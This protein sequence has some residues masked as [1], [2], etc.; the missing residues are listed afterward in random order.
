[1]GSVSTSKLA[2][3]VAD[4]GGVGSIT[5]LGMTARDL[6]E[7][8]AAMATRTAGVLV[9]N[10]LTEQIDRDAV[11]AAA[12]RVRII[13]FFWANPDRSIVDLVHAGGALGMPAGGVA[14]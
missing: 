3:A 6:N 10:F 13:D 12:S 11:V 5:A 7:T 1:M 4:A 9:A 2:V 8:L 14:R